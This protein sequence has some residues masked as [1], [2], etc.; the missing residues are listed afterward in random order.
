[1]KAFIP[2]SQFN[3]RDLEELISKTGMAF[4]VSSVPIKN[5]NNIWES[6]FQPV[7]VDNFVAI[8][9]GF[10]KPIS[11]VKYEII[12]TPKM[13]FG[14]GHHETTYMMIQSLQNVNAQKK[15]IADFGTGTGILAIL[16]S[17]LGASQILAIDH[18]EWSIR[19]AEENFLENHVD[20]VSLLNTGLFP[21]N[22]SWDLILANIN[23]LVILSNIKVISNTL[24]PGGILITSG[25]LLEDEA[26]LLNAAENC[27]LSKLSIQKRNNWL[28]IAFTKV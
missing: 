4:T 15:R 14:T 17:K 16:A 18:D 12:I 8:R 3:E 26:D 28:C 6:E 11:G 21:S 1:M 19:N 27:G 22:D 24:A 7:V 2:E 13:S 20:N 5:W 25:Y 23:K 10:H 9:A